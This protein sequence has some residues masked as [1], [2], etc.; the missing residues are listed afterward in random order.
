VEEAELTV[1][2]ARGDLGTF[3][4]EDRPW[5]VLDRDQPTGAVLP[6]IALTASAI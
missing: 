5:N 3:L 1:R 6:G 2:V 4:I